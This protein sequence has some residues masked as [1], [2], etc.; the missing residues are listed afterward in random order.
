MKYLLVLVVCSGC[1]MQLRASEQVQAILHS[2]RSK[3]V[4]HT[5]TK[6]TYGSMKKPIKTL[7]VE[8]YQE[9]TVEVEQIQAQIAVLMARL[10]QL[11]KMQVKVKPNYKVVVK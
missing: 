8:I 6:R 10:K 9:T 1:V 11:Q 5:N 7:T 2:V 4:I 3:Q